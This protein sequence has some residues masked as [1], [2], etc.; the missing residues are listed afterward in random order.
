MNLTV[1]KSTGFWVSAVTVIAGLLIS[2]G[3]VLEG[4]TVDMVIGWVLSI[5]GVIGG[6]KLAAPPTEPPAV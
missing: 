5:V 2:S 3:L 6:H 4:T 1:L